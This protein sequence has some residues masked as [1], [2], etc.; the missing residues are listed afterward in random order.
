MPWPR[1]VAPDWVR[2]RP[3]AHRGL[4][5]AERPE[6]SLAAF[7]AAAQ[8]GH[9]IELDVHRS[10]DGEVVVFHDETLQRMTGHPGAVA[11][12]PLA[13]LTGLRLGDSDERIPSLHQVLERVAGRVP[14]LVELKP[15]ERAGPLEQAVCDVLA[16]WPGDYAVQSFDPYSMIWMRRHAPHLPRGMLSGDFHDED[17]PLHQRLALRNLALAP[18]VRPAF[19]GY[20]LWSLPY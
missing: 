8:A 20:E 7:E 2:Y 10:A 4:H 5:D 19:V 12:T 17:L 11:Q 16:R 18:W 14:V 3:I 9:P 15:P 6:N 13:T 1:V